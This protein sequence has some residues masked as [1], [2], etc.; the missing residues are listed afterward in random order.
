MAV[1]IYGPGYIS[2]HP[3]HGLCAI[4]YGE[5]EAMLGVILEPLW[6]QDVNGNLHRI[7]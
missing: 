4:V 5:Y 7:D 6:V 2:E 1:I 3:I